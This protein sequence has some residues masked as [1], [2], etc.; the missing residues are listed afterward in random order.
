MCVCVFISLLWALL[1]SLQLMRRYRG[2]SGQSG[3]RTH[4][5]TAG[6]RVKPNR[7]GHR[8]AFPMMDSI[9]KIY[10]T[11]TESHTLFTHTI[12]STVHLLQVITKQGHSLRANSGLGLLS[13]P[14]ICLTS[15]HFEHSLKGN[16]E[17]SYSSHKSLAV[18]KGPVYSLLNQS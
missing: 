8:E 14:H 7:R 15:N 2:L 5:S 1:S 9:P 4:C 17:H 13:F 16:S 3:S 18:K 6:S 11:H 12:Y 10:T